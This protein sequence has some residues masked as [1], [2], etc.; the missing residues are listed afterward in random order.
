MWVEVTDAAVA[1]Q[2]LTDA[3]FPAPDAVVAAA[4]HAVPTAG[5]Q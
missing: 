1:V 5:A 2:E 4:S 3:A